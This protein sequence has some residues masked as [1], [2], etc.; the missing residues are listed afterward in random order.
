MEINALSDSLNQMQNGLG[1]LSDF[2][3]NLQKEI[4]PEKLSELDPA[5][6]SEVEKS[7]KDLQAQMPNFDKAMSQFTKAQS[8]IGDYK[9]KNK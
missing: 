6:R 4:T 9:G 1:G 7:M 5:K 2:V 8:I 3:K